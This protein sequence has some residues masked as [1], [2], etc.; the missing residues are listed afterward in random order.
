M[1]HNEIETNIENLA[2]Q[3]LAS[4]SLPTREFSKISDQFHAMTWQIPNNK[5]KRKTDYNNKY[6]SHLDSIRPLK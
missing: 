3:L 6:S 1:T 2:N 4:L 5:K